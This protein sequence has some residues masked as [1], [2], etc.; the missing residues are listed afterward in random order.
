MADQL[1]LFGWRIE[2]FR[3]LGFAQSLP[4]CHSCLLDLDPGR[5]ADAGEGVDQCTALDAKRTTDRG[6]GGAVIER[7]RHRGEFLGVNGGGTAAMASASPCRGKSGL[8]PFL[9]EGPFELSERPKNVKQKLALWRSGIHLFGQRT[10]GD[11]ALL[12]VSYRGEEMGQRSAEPVQLLDD[13]A[14]TGLDESQRLAQASTVTA[15]PGD[16]ILKQVT[17]VHPGGEK[18]VTLQ[19]QNLAVTAGGHAHVADQ[20]VRKTSPEGFP[21]SGSFRHHLSYTFWG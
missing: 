9:D 16:P 2:Q 4:S 10:K 19:V 14:I 7:R 11:T 20:H 12:E 15:A 5:P 1:T 8:D 6:F 3:N 18:R 21:H 17:F 13:Q